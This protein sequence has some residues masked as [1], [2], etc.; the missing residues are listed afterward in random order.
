MGPF[1]IWC[2]IRIVFTLQI[3]IRTF[4]VS[5]DVCY[6]VFLRGGVLDIG[7]RM[8]NGGIWMHMGAYGC[9][10]GAYEYK[11]MHTDDVVAPPTSPPCRQ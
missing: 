8:R 4:S 5:S 2:W 10:T 6:L 9:V 1:A 3:A 7:V 11:R